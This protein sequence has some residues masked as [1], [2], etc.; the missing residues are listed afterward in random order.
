M[1]AVSVSIDL[2]TAS[3]TSMPST[4]ADMM[5][6]A[7]PAPSPA[8][9][10]PTTFRLCRSLPRVMRKGDDVRV[11]TPVSTASGVEKPLICFS[12]AGSASRI[13]STA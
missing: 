7:Y 3:A 10:S 5:P 12:K 11:S 6:P 1:S 8:G 4:P 13:A 2:A 9:K